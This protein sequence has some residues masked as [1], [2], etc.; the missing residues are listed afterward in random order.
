M[1]LKKK[2]L[3]SFGT[4]PEIIKLAPIINLLKKKKVILN[5]STAVNIIPKI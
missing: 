2:I 5:L 1:I 3:V 4:R